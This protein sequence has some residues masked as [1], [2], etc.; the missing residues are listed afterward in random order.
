MKQLTV[1]LRLIVAPNLQHRARALIILLGIAVSVCLVAWNVR[2]FELARAQMLETARQQ[3]RFDVAITPKDFRGAQIAPAIVDALRQDTSIAEMD[4]AV[5]SRVQVLDPELQPMFG[6][7]GGGPPGGGRPGGGPPGAAP[8]GASRSSGPPGSGLMRGGP[9][10]GTT[11]IGTGL[12]EPPMGIEEGCWL[13]TAP[14]E[15]VLSRRFQERASLKP[16]GSLVVAG[17]GAELRL[18]VVGIMASSGAAPM[19]G[20]RMMPPPHLA[21][22]YVSPATA[23]TL[24][25]YTGRPSLLCIALKNPGDAEAFSKAW[26]DRLAAAQPAAALRLLKSTDNPMGGPSP[27][28]QQ[29][30]YNSVTIV[31]A[32][33]AAAFI[34]FAALSAGVRERMRQFAILRSLALSGLQLVCMVFLESLLFVLAGWGVGLLLT[35][36]GVPDF[37]Q[38]GVLSFR[39]L[40][41]T[42]VILSGLS[43]LAG[44]LAAALLPAWQ[45]FRIR[46]IDILSGQ[47]QARSGAFPW[48]LVV[49]GVLLIAINPIL[50][51]SAQRDESIRSMLSNF[52]GWGPRGFGAP[53]AGSIPMIIGFALLTPAA[54]AVAERWF[55][56]FLAWVLCLDRRFLR[57]QLTGNLWRTGGTTIALSAGLGLFVTSLVWGSSMR[58]PFTP[59]SGLPRMQIAI[60][61]AGLPEDAVAEVKAVPGIKADECLAMAVEQPRLTEEMLKS[62]PF[63]HV[64]EQQQHLLFMGIDPQ[65]AFG[66][67]RPLFRLDFSAGDSTTAARKLAEGRYCVVPEQFV[68]QTG[69]KVGDSFSV[70]VPNARGRQVSYTIAGVASVPGWNWLT[71]FSETRRRA[72][73]ALAMV[74]VGYEQAKADFALDR[75]S[76]FWTNV[77]DGV[78]SQDLETRIAPLAKRHAGVSVDVPQVGQTAV[79]VQTVKITDREEVIA[80]LNRRADSVIQPLTTLP[81]IT[82]VISSLALFNAILASIRARFWQIGVLRGVGLTGSQLLRLILAESLLIGGA[83]CVLSLVSGL[84]LAWCGTRLCTLFFFFAGN[85]P[86]LVVPWLELSWGF[87]LAVG[88]SILAGLIPAALAARKEPLGFI[89]EGRMAI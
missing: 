86:P 5:K 13:G 40:G 48:I 75:V 72:G 29:M 35:V 8:G 34:I 54:V 27:G 89:Q 57:Q 70:D 68:T 18:N 77:E 23:G 64:D 19:P 80:M 28:I 49:A 78:T 6:P 37:F 82:L 43:A 20:V 32:F 71:K 60:L 69:L 16:G 36:S 14:N 53:L 7:P 79:G 11:V 83:A 61:P 87:G 76:Y 22:V 55:G 10:G 50:V 62:P 81:L 33:L 63:A 4:A 65:R 84:G 42:A 51:V 47:G 31:A 66:G 58:V 39:P 15:A 67:D 46:P 2:S 85:T 30:I 38:S 26:K 1:L 9:F 74:F 12:S 3:G 59:T 17:M 45:A 73:R 88:V 41:W 21:D 52:W 56:P 44:A 25:G 24:N